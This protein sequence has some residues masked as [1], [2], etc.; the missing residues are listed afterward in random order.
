MA[1][2]KQVQSKRNMSE[3]EYQKF[4]TEVGNKID[5]N[6]RINALS[7]YYG[8]TIYYVGPAITDAMYSSVEQENPVALIMEYLQL[9][10]REELDLTHYGLIA[11]EIR[12]TTEK[13]FLRYGDR[14]CITPA[15]T[16]NYIHSEG[17]PLDTQA[18]NMSITHGREITPD[19]LV[20]FI[21]MYEHG[22]ASYASEIQK[23]KARLSNLYKQMVGATL[24]DKFVSRFESEFIT[25]VTSEVTEEAPF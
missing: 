24:T 3:K 25:Q 2:R 7:S 11:S 17:T 23:E 16:R 14:N 18:Q 21:L 22:A 5:W 9:M 12:P 4:A 1:Y 10:Q 20:E 15:L 8:T 19:D 13:S 6:R